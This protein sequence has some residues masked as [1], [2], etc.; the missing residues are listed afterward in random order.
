V[1][2]NTSQALPQTPRGMLLPVHLSMLLPVRGSMLSLI[3]IPLMKGRKLKLKAEIRKQLIM[4]LVASARSRRFQHRQVSTCSAPPQRQAARSP[5]P[6]ARPYIRS[7]TVCSQCTSVP[8]HTRLH[9]L[10][11]LAS[12]LPFPDCCAECTNVPVHTQL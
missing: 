1:A 9:L 7:L 4:F 11:G 2:S 3:S 8:V 5:T 12:S 6:A 10:P